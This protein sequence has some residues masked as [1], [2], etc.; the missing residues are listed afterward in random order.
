MRTKKCLCFIFGIFALFAFSGCQNTLLGQFEEASSSSRS[1]E[2]LSHEFQ[3]D[4]NGE[5]AKSFFP[6]L[7]T[8]PESVRSEFEYRLIPSFGQT[9]SYEG[10]YLRLVFDTDKEYQDFFV[11]TERDHPDMTEDQRQHSFF[12]IEST[13]FAVEDYAFR[14]IDLSEYGS[15]DP[16]IG[17][18]AHCDS[19]RTVVF[20]YFW[21]D[22][23]GIED[24]SDGLGPHGYMDY[25]R[26]SW[27]S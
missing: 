17:L 3:D 27:R 1:H 23:G 7:Q 2:I 25:Y 16:Y 8:L 12:I 14:A 26:D 4:Q 5:I 24:I 21:H 20:L 11:E 13:R 10:Y 18:I 15:T 19:Q 6:D 9:P 22:L